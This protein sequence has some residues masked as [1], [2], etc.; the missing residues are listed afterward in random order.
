MKIRL[1]AV[2]LAGVL[3]L[4]GCERDARETA[5]PAGEPTPSPA[6]DTPN[7]AQD[8]EPSYLTAT[9]VDGA[10]TGALLLACVEGA[11]SPTGWC[12]Y[13]AGLVAGICGIRHMAARWPV[14]RKGLGR[15]P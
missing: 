5:I 14:L 10:E 4:S 1:F 2:L 9:I 6:V 7:L 12:H 11:G 15:R 13:V 8:E 3:M